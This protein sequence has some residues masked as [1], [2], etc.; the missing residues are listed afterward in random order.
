VRDAAVIGV[1]DDH[2]GERPVAI[3]ALTP[4]AVLDLQALTAHSRAHLGGF[5]VPKELLLV[6]ELPRNATGK[7][8]KREL[9]RMYAG[10]SLLHPTTRDSS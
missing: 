9:R 1:P 6:A 2:W 3:V 5:K 4:G 10:S 7:V 8:L